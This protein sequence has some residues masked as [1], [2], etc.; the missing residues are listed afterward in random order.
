MGELVC[1]EEYKEKAFL[2]EIAE[3]RVELELIMSS[4]P[5]EES[6][7][8][9]LSLEEMDDIEKTWLNERNKK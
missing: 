4:W 5:E 8:Y 9:F 2:Q 7:G 1:L 6:T 3:L